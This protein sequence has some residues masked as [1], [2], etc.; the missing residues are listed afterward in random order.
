MGTQEVANAE[1]CGV[2]SWGDS[3]K[4]IDTDP[5]HSHSPATS[6][7]SL[8]ER[9]EAHNAQHGVT[10]ALGH[11][12]YSD[13]TS[14]EFEAHFKLGAHATVTHKTAAEGRASTQRQSME[15]AD[16]LQL[17]DYGTLVWLELKD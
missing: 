15:L 17:P 3:W 16:P 8:P 6:S 4:S 2:Y 11:N 14:D 5:S 10:Y 7:L 9:I 1:T 12:E 13:M